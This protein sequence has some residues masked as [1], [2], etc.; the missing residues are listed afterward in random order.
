MSVWTLLFSVLKLVICHW[1]KKIDF[2]V[3][4]FAAKP[5]PQPQS[6]QNSILRL[7]ADEVIHSNQILIT[8]FLALFDCYIG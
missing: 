2:L 5:G 8:Q 7:L 4:A 3:A 6:L 1:G